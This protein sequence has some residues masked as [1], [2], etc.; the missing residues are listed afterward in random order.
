MGYTGAEVIT[1]AHELEKKWAAADPK[2]RKRIVHQFPSKQ[3]AK[4]KK[5]VKVDYPPCPRC[6][7]ESFSELDESE[8]GTVTG[9]EWGKYYEWCPVCGYLDF[10]EWFID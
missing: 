3:S 9:K 7:Y 5:W 10:W 4:Q 8:G 6:G 2:T 1:L